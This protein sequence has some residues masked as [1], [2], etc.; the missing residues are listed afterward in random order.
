MAVTGEEDSG[1]EAA[2]PG[3]GDG[4]LEC[5][6]GKGWQVFTVSSRGWGGFEMER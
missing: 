1:G 2:D 4:D 3:S 6:G 5:H